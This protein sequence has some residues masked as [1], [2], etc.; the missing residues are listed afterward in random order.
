VFAW[1]YEEMLSID[2]SIVVEKIPM[3][4]GAKRVRQCLCPVHPR[5]VAAIKGEVEKLLKVGFI[6]PIPLTDWVFNIVLTTKK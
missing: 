3:Y 1:S 4:L 2:P 5:K 6:Y